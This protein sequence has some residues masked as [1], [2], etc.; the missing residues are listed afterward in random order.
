[1]N[2]IEQ[3]FKLHNSMDDKK[4][5]SLETLYF[6]IKP[7]QLYQWVLKRKP[8]SYQYTWSLFTRELEAQYKHFWE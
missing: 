8:P 1:V 5:I 6:E 3:Y 7:Y 2:Q 4:R